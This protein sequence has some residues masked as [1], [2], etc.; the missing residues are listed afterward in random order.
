ML[1]YSLSGVYVCEIREIYGILNGVWRGLLTI[2]DDDDD[3]LS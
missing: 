1:A 2:H 3:T